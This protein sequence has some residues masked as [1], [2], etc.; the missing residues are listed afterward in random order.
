MLPFPSPFL[1]LSLSQKKRSIK[2]NLKNIL[3][4]KHKKISQKR[5]QPINICVPLFSV[6][7]ANFQKNLNVCAL[8]SK[9]IQLNINNLK[10]WIYWLL[11]KRQKTYLYHFQLE[12]MS[13]I[14]T[15]QRKETTGKLTKN[16]N[17][18]DLPIMPGNTRRGSFFCTGST[19][20]IHI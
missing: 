15:S 8:K 18:K 11:F 19:R 13:L 12:N 14:I 9:I 4:E 6:H 10:Y 5:T 17:I 2:I 1:F 7:T 16:K 3:K 20:E